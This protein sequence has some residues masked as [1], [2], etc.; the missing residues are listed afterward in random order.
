MNVLFRTLIR[1]HAQG[2]LPPALRSRLREHGFDF[3]FDWEQELTDDG[4]TRHTHG[5]RVKPVTEADEAR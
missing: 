1:L 3:R 5:L 4:N 2:S